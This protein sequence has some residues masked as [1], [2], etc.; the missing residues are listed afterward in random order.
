MV[1]FVTWWCVNWHKKT[2]DIIFRK[3]SAY[4]PAATIFGDIHIVRIFGSH[5][6]Q[7][8]SFFDACDPQKTRELSAG[9]PRPWWTKN[10]PASEV[11]QCNFL[12]SD[13]HPME[14]KH[15]RPFLIVGRCC[16]GQASYDM[17][18]SENGTHAI[19]AKCKFEGVFS[20]TNPAIQR[21]PIFRQINIIWLVVWNMNFIFNHIL[22]IVI[23]C[24]PNETAK[25]WLIF[26]RG[27]QTTNQICYDQIHPFLQP[28]GGPRFSDIASS[29]PSHLVPKRCQ[30]NAKEMP[31]VNFKLLSVE[32]PYI[33]SSFS[34]LTLR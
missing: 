14:F 10:A 16:L 18:V 32:F 25:Q 11:M 27:V 2:S 22:G 20:V 13:V 6:I 34:N 15:H 8:I 3:F 28:A 5:W 21:Y 19:P 33:W 1:I 29:S 24:D 4:N 9:H 31:R 17:G 30:Q 7:V 23:P 26:F 12:P